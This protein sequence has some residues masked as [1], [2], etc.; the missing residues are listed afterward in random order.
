MT[1]CVLGSINQDIVAT[2]RALP[3]T[4]ETIMAE[5]LADYPGGKGANQAIAAARM[6]APTRMV[7]AVGDDGAGDG[8][9]RY[10]QSAGV[11]ISAVLVKRDCRTGQAFINVG[12]AGENT[13]V[14]APGANHALAPVDLDLAQIGA[15]R[16]FL[17]QMETPTPVIETLFAAVPSAGGLRLLN[18]APA[19]MDA[20][21]LLPLVD[22]LIVNETELASLAGLECLPDDRQRQVEVARALLNRPGQR[23]VVT[24]GSAGAIAVDARDAVL[25]PGRETDAVDTT[26]AGDCFCGALAAALA[27]GAA[28]EAALG[29]A[30]LAASLSVECAGAAASM[31]TRAR[32][33]ELARI[34]AGA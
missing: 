5:Q 30:N 20:L 14:V 28:M 6:G 32:V 1:V 10:L 3:R 12:A 22:I 15:A 26:G 19:N 27:E 34:T 33:D 7:G 21:S 16:V 9:R 17:A 18:A 13:I 24:L 31:P 8:L 11:D 25:V 2:V 23:V 4:G 29:M